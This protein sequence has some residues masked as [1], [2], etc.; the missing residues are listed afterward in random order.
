LNSLQL[1][2]DE[3]SLFYFIVTI[4]LIL[5]LVLLLFIIYFGIPFVRGAPF[6]VSTPGK[7][8]K[9][10]ELVKRYLGDRPRAKAADLGSGDGRLVLALAANGLEAHGLEI[11]PFLVWY[12]RRKVKKAGPE[13]AFIHRADYLKVNLS[14]YDIIV[15]FGVFYMM[16]R[17]EQKLKNELRPGALIISNY[18][19]FPHWQ[20]IAE[21]DKIFVYRIERIPSPR[22]I[23]LNSGI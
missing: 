13:N 18:F 22:R 6:A 3:Q 14:E 21:Q 4:E 8:K 19:R 16:D 23:V 15:L 10:L 5:I 17:L 2:I 11:N 12:S 7:T 1:F 20:P 9:M